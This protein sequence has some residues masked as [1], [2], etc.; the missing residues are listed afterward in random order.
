M[1]AQYI[2]I[3]FLGT[4]YYSDKAMTKLYREDGPAVELAGG[5]KLWYLN[6]KCHR[7]DG[8]AMIRNNG[9][10]YWFIN[11]KRVTEQ[12][13]RDFYTPSTPK[14]ININDKWFTL[15]ELNSLIE[16]VKK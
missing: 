9:K 11:D 3:N 13:H 7:E 5:S 12:E 6:G 16:T 1:K 4:Y 8:P 14:T 15:E 2:V 10:C